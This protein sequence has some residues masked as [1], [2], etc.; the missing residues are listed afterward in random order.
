MTK[1]ICFLLT[2]VCSYGICCLNGA[3]LISRLV[4][5]EDVR[6]K[7][8]GNAGLTNFIRVY[9]TKSAVFVVLVD[10]MKTVIAVIFSRW[11]F[12]RFVGDALLGAYWSG[13]WTTIGHSYPCTE[14]FRGGKGI[15]CGGTLL[16]LIDWRIAVIGL[17]LFALAVLLTRY[18]SLGSLLAT[19]SFPITTAIFFSAEPHAPWL[20]ALSSAVAA[21]IFWSHRTNI[22]RLIRGT[23]SKFT[24]HK[25]DE[26]TAI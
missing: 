26:P 14:G 25:K 22:V 5:R 10:V 21:S 9:G 18:V 17:G 23:E 2:A 16:V 8:S 6:K 3:L 7:G 12:G 1:T 19:L 15:L 11:I 24:L 4:Y 13:L 20:I